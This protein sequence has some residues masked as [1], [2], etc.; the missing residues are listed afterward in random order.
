[1]QVKEKEDYTTIQADCKYL[2]SNPKQH[3][4]T[5]MWSTW[6]QITMKLEFN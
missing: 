2:H 1:M 3:M 4:S 5:E 6:I